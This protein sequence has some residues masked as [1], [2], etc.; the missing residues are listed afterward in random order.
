MAEWMSHLSRM[1]GMHVAPSRCAHRTF[2]K[3]GCTSLSQR[4]C[5]ISA[6]IST[7]SCNAFNPTTTHPAP[8]DTQLFVTNM[9]PRVVR[10]VLA[11][12]P[13]RNTGKRSA[14]PN[15]SEY[16]VGWIAY[17]SS[18]VTDSST[19]ADDVLH[20]DPMDVRNPKQRDA[21]CSAGGCLCPIS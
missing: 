5:S 3:F 9:V 11:S 6:L 17:I 16:M 18:V 15:A 21:G 19:G 1:I 7:L 14:N 8:L 20:I 12:L 2:W 10:K 4:G 13:C